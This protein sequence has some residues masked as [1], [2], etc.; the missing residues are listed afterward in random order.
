MREYASVW[1]QM[2]PICLDNSRIT[3]WGCI[4]DLTCTPL[5]WR[6]GNLCAWSNSTRESR[7]YQKV[8]A[9]RN[10]SR[11]AH[12]E[13]QDKMKLN[14]QLGAY[15]VTRDDHANQWGSTNLNQKRKYAPVWHQMC[16]RSEK[17]SDLKSSIIK[18]AILVIHVH[19]WIIP[20]DPRGIS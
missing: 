11:K 7:L 10:D 14:H 16:D 17:S 19:N 8:W 12:M 1:H 15:L 5:K 9:W 4:R 2:Y 6:C 20:T 13:N 3:P 18:H